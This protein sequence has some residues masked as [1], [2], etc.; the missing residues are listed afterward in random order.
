MDLM[1][2]AKTFR[3]NRIARFVY[4]LHI[5]IHSGPV[6]YRKCCVCARQGSNANKRTIAHAHWT[7]TCTFTHICIELGSPKE[8]QCEEGVAG[9]GW[10]LGIERCARPKASSINCMSNIIYICISQSLSHTC[11]TCSILK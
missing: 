3:S 1:E 10:R 11:S 4:A 8:V 5:H 7:R 2:T 6:W 9:G